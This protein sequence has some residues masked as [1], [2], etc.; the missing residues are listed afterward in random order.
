M[1][2]VATLEPDESKAERKLRKQTE[3]LAESGALVP[4]LV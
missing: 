2:E 3:K 4:A 1:D